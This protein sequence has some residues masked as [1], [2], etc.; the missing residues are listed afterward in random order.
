MHGT[1]WLVIIESANGITNK[2]VDQCDNKVESFEV[3]YS[4]ANV[5]INSET[6]QQ[7]LPYQ[8]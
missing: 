8:L 6:W 3:I 1:A 5:A 4:G 2:K 7:S